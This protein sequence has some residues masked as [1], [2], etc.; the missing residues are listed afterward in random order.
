[1]YNEFDETQLNSSDSLNLLFEKYSKIFEANPHS[2]V[3]APLAECFRKMGRKD[4]ALSLLRDGIKNHPDY[5]LGY[6]GLAQCYFELEQLNLA[7]NTL[8]SLIEKNRENIRL[9]RLFAKIC[10]GTNHETEALESYKYLLFLNPRDPEAAYKV[11]ML[12]DPILQKSEEKTFSF[13]EDKVSDFFESDEEN[14]W[15]SVSFQKLEILDKMAHFSH[16]KGDLKSASEF[17]ELSL[18]IN[19]KDIWAQNRARQLRSN[20]SSHTDGSKSYKI[21]PQKITHKLLDFLDKIK[22][23]SFEVQNRR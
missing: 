2:T 21:T 11:R 9:Q 3:F 18:T 5:L 1:M 14:N 6:L 12:E 22:K 13:K 15:E 16:R 8:R 17:V 20:D 19:P 10:E 7:Y 4:K 23:R